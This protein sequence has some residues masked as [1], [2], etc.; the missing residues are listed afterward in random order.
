MHKKLRFILIGVIALSNVTAYSQAVNDIV[1]Q[2]AGYANQVWYSLTNDEQGSAPKAEWDIAFSIS[3]F[4]SSIH[5]NPANGNIVKVYPDGTINDWDNVDATNFETWAEVNNSAT[6]WELGAFDQNNSGSGLDFGWGVYNPVTH[7]V[8]GD[9]LYIVQTGEGTLK[10][11]KLINLTLAGVYNFEIADI[12]GDNHYTVAV[13]K[14]D[15]AGKQFGYYSIANNE[16]LD[17]DPVSATWDL[18]FMQYTEFVPVAYTVAGVLSNPNVEVLQVDGVNTDTFEDWS[19]EYSTEKNVIGYD[20]KSFNGAG[21][22]ITA[23]RVYFIRDQEG[24][25]WKLV[26]TGF[27]GSATGDY[28][29][30]KE[31]I[32]TASVEDLSSTSILQVYPNPTT[33][34]LNIVT[35]NKNNINNQL[36]I[37]DING[38]V[39]MQEN[40]VAIQGLQNNTLNVS[41]LSQGLY[42][43]TISNSLSSET[44]KFQV[45]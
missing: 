7:F 25:I 21:Y 15:Y 3:S 43:L 40:L 6:D 33:D 16:L 24:N 27:G 14:A 37:S 5:I 31:L 28:E 8:T 38:R 45:R 41:N 11:I 23:D 35:D 19:G 34:V 36:I 30:T 26:F 44:V 4:S 9:S 17:R 42:F 20:W 18:T 2:G 39:V 22:D 1:S 29:F 32:S 13:N 10:K 12:N